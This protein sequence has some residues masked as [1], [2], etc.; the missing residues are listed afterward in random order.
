MRKSILKSRAQS[1]CIA[2]M[3]VASLPALAQAPKQES[4]AIT[5]GAFSTQ[6]IQ[7]E[8]KE[9]QLKQLL[10]GKTLYLRDGYLDNSLDFDEHG[11]LTSHSSRGSFT[12]SQV[13]INKIKLSKHKLELQGDRYGLHFLGAAPF[14]DPTK[15]TD[16]VKITPKKKTVR[17]S[18]DREQVEK[19]KEKHKHKGP[20]NAPAGQQSNEP[21]VATAAP[22]PSAQQVIPD[23]SDKG[24]TTTTSPAHASQLLVSALDKVFSIG[25]DDRMIAS[26]PDFWRIYYQASAAH[27][28]IKPTDPGILRQ[29][30]VDLKA[31][32]VSAIDP[33]SNEFAQS[34][35]IAGMALYHAVVG[36]DGK[37]QAVVAG[38]PIG[39]GLDENAEKVIRAASFQPALKAG[40]PVPV[41][42]DLIVSFRIY[43]KRTSQSAAHATVD[44][45]TDA[46]ANTRPGPYTAHALE[47]WAQQHAPGTQPQPSSP[48]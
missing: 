21:R 33:P 44:D 13:Q 35:G 42:I 32:L 38:R 3:I 18:F 6:T 28:D 27:A 1:A 46:S 37:V 31:T 8:L 26:M 23:N 11:V 14:E 39:F 19:P 5:A 48:Q 25:I 9:D 2:A 41:A 45:E 47:T 4:P 36:A 24:T 40:K 16:R 22:E 30:A 12:L 29:N 15:A 43:S 17:I 10:I 20:D 34:S 7:G